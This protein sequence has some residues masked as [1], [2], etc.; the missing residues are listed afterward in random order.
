[1]PPSTTA[2]VAFG[3]H[4][5]LFV[6]HEARTV[7]SEPESPASARETPPSETDASTEPSDIAPSPLPL[8]VSA[9]ERPS[10][11]D[12]CAS[13]SPANTSGLPDGAAPSVDS[14]APSDLSPGNVATQ[15]ATHAESAISRTSA[16][17]KLANILIPTSLLS[18][19]HGVHAS[20]RAERFVGYGR[21]V[22]FTRGD[23]SIRDV[24]KGYHPWRGAVE[25][26]RRFRVSG[27][28]VNGNDSMGFPY[29][30][31]IRSRCCHGVRGGCWQG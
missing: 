19:K 1:M 13:P 23:P 6:A 2:H 18:A 21:A 15:P 20:W 29:E 7:R 10:A 9:S 24:G 25:R 17:R 26:T 30:R 28:S 11:S 3:S 31:A 5:P 27:G 4:P 22:D 8:S 12:P 16:T 14:A